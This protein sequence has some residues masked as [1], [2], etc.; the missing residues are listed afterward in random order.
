MCIKAN[1][2]V[3]VRLKKG[4]LDGTL[5]PW[6]SRGRRLINKSCVVFLIALFLCAYVSTVRNVVAQS[7]QTVS[8][9]QAA[10]SAI[11]Q[12]FDAVLDA[13]KAGANVTGLLARLNAAADLLAQAEIAVRKGDSNAG[14]KGDSVLS[15]AGEV[16]TAAVA[17]RDAALGAGQ[18]ALYS[19]VAFSSVGV[20]VFVLVLF[21]VWRQSKQSN[22]K[23]VFEAKPEVSVS[24][25]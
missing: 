16:E 11:D 24:E 23:S 19:T 10:E 15:I 13:E 25:A 5:G 20:V 9:L 7:D 17:A 6:F 2:A 8:K 3:M 1:I 22:V 14:A 12:A 18:N 21:L 4:E